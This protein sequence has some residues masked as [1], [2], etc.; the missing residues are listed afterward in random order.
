MAGAQTR[1]LH[2]HPPP[3]SA[4]QR[5]WSGSQSVG[6]SW[7]TS[8]SAQSDDSRQRYN[9]VERLGNLIATNAYNDGPYLGPQA[10]AATI[11]SDR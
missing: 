11:C 2:H 10:P 5:T 6:L 3:P 8:V 4:F 9:G 7:L 1:A